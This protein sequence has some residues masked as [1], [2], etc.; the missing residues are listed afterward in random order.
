M[1]AP[2]G[3]NLQPWRFVVVRDSTLKAKL[4]KFGSDFIQT[5]PVVIVVC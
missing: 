4:A 5:A 3:M 2:T 1:A